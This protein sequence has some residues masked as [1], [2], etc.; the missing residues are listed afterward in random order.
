MDCRQVRTALLAPDVDTAAVV[1][2]HLGH[3]AACGRVAIALG[4]LDGLLRAHLLA[5]PSAE[6]ER[7]L[8]ALAEADPGLR[9]D[10]A[11]NAALVAEPPAALQASLA[12]LVPA[13]APA[14]SPAPA[15]TRIDR[16]L[17]AELVSQPPVALQA[18]LASLV[19][20][21][22]AAVARIDQAVRAGTL[23]D[24]P[25]GLQASLASLVPRDEPESVD[26]LAW[27]ARAW[28][29]LWSRPAVLGGQLAAVAV[30][31]YVVVQLL[32]WLGTLPVVVGDIPYALELLVLSPAVDYLAQFETLLQ[33]LG[34]WLIV[35]AA[36]WILVQ[37][38]PFGRR[39]L[40]P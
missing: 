5:L 18:S 4:R 24:P 10:H 2:A 36:G 7:R 6:L 14:L 23:V 39:Q 31:G 15:A 1:A 20:A 3:C 13:S 22:A 40:E 16:A 11:L 25:A 12:A 19:P 21:P 29:D 38:L 28:R 37:G 9:V 33:Q 27:L 26:A 8:L 35:A 17:C 32:A 34:L 30:L